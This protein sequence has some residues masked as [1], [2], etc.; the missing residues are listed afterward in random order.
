[1]LAFSRY[2]SLANK[3]QPYD[4]AQSLKSSGQSWQIASF[5]L[6]GVAAAGVGVGIVGF[7]LGSPDARPEA[8]KITG[9]RSDGRSRPRRWPGRSRGG[10]A[11]NGAN[12]ARVGWAAALIGL[13]L[14][15]NFDAAFARYCSNNPYC[16]GDAAS[17]RGQ[18]Q[19]SP[20]CQP[21]SRAMLMWQWST[22][23]SAGRASCESSSDCPGPAQ[24]CIKQMCMTTCSANG[25]CPPGNDFCVGS[26]GPGSEPPPGLSGR[27]GPTRG[28]LCICRSSYS[29]AAMANGF[30]CNPG[31]G[32]CEPPC[33]QPA[34][35]AT[36]VPPR[37]CD[38]DDHLC[39]PWCRSN[40][41]CSGVLPAAL[42]C[43]QW[44][45]WRMRQP[46]RL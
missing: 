37:T 23:A 7:A 30:L 24:I 14:S 36:F 9:A 2:A 17:D 21:M 5:I 34:D 18:D 27:Y 33:Y 22:Q 15:C 16:R 43:D 38:T 42:R 12:A 45:V 26:G 10:V 40:M 6:S 3:M 44:P 29:C 28:G 20:Q 8:G 13:G 31:D 39:K 1:M 41:S 25:D 4:S 11:V 46:G 35:C 32:L 19:M